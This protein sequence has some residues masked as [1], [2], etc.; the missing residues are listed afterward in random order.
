MTSDM[1]SSPSPIVVRRISR[2]N[3]G[4]PLDRYGFPHDIAHDI[5]HFISYSNILPTH[6]AFITLLDS[7]TL[8]KSW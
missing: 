4:V 5:A 1:I 8:P 3:A 2:S 7:L 6:R